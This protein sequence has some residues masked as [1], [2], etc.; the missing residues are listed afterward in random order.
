MRSIGIIKS[1]LSDGVQSIGTGRFGM[2]DVLFCGQGR[3][4]RCFRDREVVSFFVP[5]SCRTISTHVNIY[6][7]FRTLS[8]SFFLNIEQLERVTSLKVLT[9]DMSSYLNWKSQIL[10][11]SKVN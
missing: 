7:A 2:E 8:A 1:F 6:E 10:T 4:W 5:T 9:L 11:L 3:W